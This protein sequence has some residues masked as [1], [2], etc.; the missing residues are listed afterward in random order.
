[1][2]VPPSAAPGPV[3]GHG[4]AATLL[5]AA[6]LPALAHAA[7]PPPLAPGAPATRPDIAGAP[8]RHAPLPLQRL[9]GSDPADTPT[10]AGWRAAHEA[11]GAFPRGHADIVAW[12]ARQAGAGTAPSTAPSTP[13][14]TH[15]HSHGSGQGMGGHGMHTAPGAGPHRHPGGGKP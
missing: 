1:M 8:L 6:L 13:S 3:P 14:G 10:D 7:E 15:S 5:A 11:V 2:P 9:P 4:V 12:E